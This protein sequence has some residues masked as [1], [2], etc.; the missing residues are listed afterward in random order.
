MYE[1]MKV[2][3]TL[4]NVQTHAAFSTRTRLQ[5]HALVW[6]NSSPDLHPLQVDR[7]GVDALTHLDAIARAVLTVRGRQVKQVR[8]VLREQGVRAE[9]RT[10]ATRAE[11][12][13]AVPLRCTRMIAIRN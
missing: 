9:V 4:H 1:S 8:A 7:L 6:K 3:L 12:H 13:R 5:F 11:N 10:E 2:G